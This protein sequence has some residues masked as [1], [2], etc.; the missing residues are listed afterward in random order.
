[1]TKSIQCR[2]N[3]KVLIDHHPFHESINKN[4]LKDL[5]TKFPATRT[6]VNANDKSETNIKALQ[7]FNDIE[8]KEISLICDWVSKIIS[9]QKKWESEFVIRDKWIAIYQN[10]D[11][12][13]PHTHSPSIY[14]FVYFIRCSKNSSP[15]IF[16]TSGKKIKAEEGKV[17][18]FPANLLHHVPK[19]KSKERIILSGNLYYKL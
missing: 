11:Y 2:E 17:V 19:N 9:G 12:T 1:M 3:L 10:G 8:S 6:I 13:I 15:L 7:T 16:T 5:S 4:L 18:I 14:A